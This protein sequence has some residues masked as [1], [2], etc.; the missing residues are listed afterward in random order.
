MAR[1][2]VFV[3]TSTATGSKGIYRFTFDPETGAAGPVELAAESAN[4]TWLA[5][6]PNG[7]YLY[8]VNAIQEFRGER[9]GSISA[10]ALDPKTGALTLLNQE[11]SGGPGPCHVQ[12][13]RDGHNVLTAN[14]MGGS[15]AVLPLGADGK[16]YPPSSRIQ[17]T[18][19]SIN[20]KRQE[21]PHAH[22]I[23][24]DAENQFA[25]VPDLGLDQVLIYR[26]D[27]GRGQL[28][29]NDPP[30]T[31]VTPGAGPRHLSFHPNGRYAYAINEL[32]STVTVFS[33]DSQLGTLWEI[34]T[35]TTLP[36]GWSGENY[37]AEVRVHPGG[38]FL[39]GSNRGHDSIASYAIHPETGLLTPLGQQ[40]TE[41]K[42]PRNFAFDLTGDWVIA[43]NQNSDNFRVF[44]LDRE[45]GA[46]TPTDQVVECPAPICFKFLPVGV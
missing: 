43:G 20:P 18:G 25:L 38:R 31:K 28:K 46:L 3:G 34:Q 10:F 21:A 19:S 5:L 35:V 23:N 41:G 16:L 36:E 22:S 14:Y 6:H 1:Q 17:H 24:L 40:S 44:R 45:S 4:P 11:P 2:W 8:S 39:Y 32:D 30:F 9:G 27:A 12:V 13:D 15:V 7:R 37:P 33:Y 29:P 26:F 42:W